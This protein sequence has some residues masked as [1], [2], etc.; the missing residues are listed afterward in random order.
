MVCASVKAVD[1]TR[2]AVPNP[3]D[4]EAIM[5]TLPIFLVVLNFH[6]ENATVGSL[7]KRVG[8]GLALAINRVSSEFCDR[9]KPN[10]FCA[11]TVNDKKADMS[12]GQA[13]L[14]VNNLAWLEGLSC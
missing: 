14:S 4:R 7:V 13:R 1:V 8:H 2:L 6:S 10:A 11:Y 5:S 9:T 3:I 12:H